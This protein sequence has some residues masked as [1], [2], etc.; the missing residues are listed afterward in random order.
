MKEGNRTVIHIM[1]LLWDGMSLKALSQHGFHA[2]QRCRWRQQELG[3]SR[4]TP[5]CLWGAAGD[6]GAEQA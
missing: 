3:L 2:Q 1:R 6:F 5:G 4:W